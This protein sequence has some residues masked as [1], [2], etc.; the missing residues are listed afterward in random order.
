MAHTVDLFVDL[1]FLLDEGI[2]ARDIGFGLV[3]VVV[4]HKVFDRVFGEKPLEFAIKLCGQRLVRSQD[5]GRAL[6]LLD[7][8]G[9]GVGLAGASRPQKNLIAVALQD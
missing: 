4:A 8:L 9:H 1:A 5:D 7:H 2:A 6:R 3:I